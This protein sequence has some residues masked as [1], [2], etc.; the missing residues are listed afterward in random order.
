MTKALKVFIL[1]NPTLKAVVMAE[2]EAEREEDFEFSYPKKKIR[3]DV[4]RTQL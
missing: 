1:N 4:Y 2:D 3:K